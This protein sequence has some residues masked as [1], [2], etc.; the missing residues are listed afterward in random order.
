MLFMLSRNGEIISAAIIADKL[1]LPGEF[2]SK[3]LQSLSRDGFLSSKKGKGGGFTINNNSSE[4]RLSDIIKRYETNSIS[5]DCV[6]GIYNSCIGQIC[7]LYDDWNKLSS[8]L[9]SRKI[10]TLKNFLH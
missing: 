9:E 10:K 8:N 1:N 6:F 4:C 5:S 3:I 2:V 7:P